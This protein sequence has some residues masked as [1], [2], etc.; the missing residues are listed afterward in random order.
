MT[1][2]ERIEIL[3]AK[4]AKAESALEFYSLQGVFKSYDGNLEIHDYGKFARDCLKEL[5]D[6][7]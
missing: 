7:K 5:R 3:E 1:D 2:E 4:L 6:E